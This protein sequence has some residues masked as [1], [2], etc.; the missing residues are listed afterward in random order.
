MGTS[1]KSTNCTAPPG[2]FVA[3]RAHFGGVGRVAVQ[4]ENTEISRLKLSMFVFFQVLPFSVSSGS[5][6]AQAIGFFGAGWRRDEGQKV[7]AIRVDAISTSI[8]VA[9]AAGC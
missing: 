2:T 3:A 7:T 1:V 4:P 9:V 5:S 8:G 6:I